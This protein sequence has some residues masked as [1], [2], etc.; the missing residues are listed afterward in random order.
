MICGRLRCGKSWKYSRERGLEGINVDV[1]EKIWVAFEKPNSLWVRVDIDLDCRV[2]KVFAAL[3]L[4]SEKEKRWVF[5]QDAPLKEQE[6]PSEEA[7]IEAF[8]F[9]KEFKVALKADAYVKVIARVICEN[10]RTAIDSAC[11]VIYSELYENIRRTASFGALVDC[12]D[13]SPLECP[14][15]F[16]R[17]TKLSY[18]QNSGIAEVRFDITSL[19]KAVEVKW[20]LWV[21]DN[22]VLKATHVLGVPVFADTY[23]YGALNPGD[24][25]RVEVRGQCKD[26]M[27]SPADW[28]ELEI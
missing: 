18:G 4:W 12:R 26:D 9:E 1:I 27:W 19:W 11:F 14:R 2:Q 23:E 25:I 16:L 5:V 21:E 8:T 7:E 28:D 24:K 22:W 20:Y 17:A 10:C 15:S 3:Y 6:L 13:L